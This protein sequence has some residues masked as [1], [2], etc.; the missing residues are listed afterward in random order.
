MDDETIRPGHLLW[1]ENA[2]KRLQIAG[3]PLVVSSVIAVWSS[4]QVQPFASAWM[5]W[6][7][8]AVLALSLLTFTLIVIFRGDD[9]NALLPMAFVAATLAILSVV[10]LLCIG[11]SAAAV[12]ARFD[13]QCSLL[14]IDAMQLHPLRADSADLF[15]KLH[16]RSQGTGTLE[17]NH[18]LPS[19]KQKATLL[20]I[21]P[22]TNAST[23]SKA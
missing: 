17:F 4:G 7:A 11:V 12:S 2:A 22:P 8:G 23:A 3:I 13:Y 9:D 5:I 16:C 6:A 14:E 20:P 21:Q 18:R 10:A 15:D 19:A 1:P